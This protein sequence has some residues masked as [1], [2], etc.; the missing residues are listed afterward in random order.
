MDQG[1][2]QVLCQGKAVYKALATGMGQGMAEVI[3]PSKAWE[4]VSDGQV[5]LGNTQVKGRGKNLITGQ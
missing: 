5:Q 3:T 1:K 2:K 4:G